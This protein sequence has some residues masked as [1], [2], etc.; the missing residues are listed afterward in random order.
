MQKY[1]TALTAIQQYCKRIQAPYREG[2][3]VIFFVRTPNLGVLCLPGCR[4]RTSARRSPPRDHLAR[5]RG[6][7]LPPKAEAGVASGTTG[8]AARVSMK[9]REGRPR[10][11][12]KFRSL[13][14]I[15]HVVQ[16][17]D[18]DKSPRTTFQETAVNSSCNSN[19]C[20]LGC[21]RGFQRFRQK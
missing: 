17:Y 10:R 13:L 19:H 9:R 18:T 20:V 12:G 11:P 14:R 16:Q 8:A 2:S 6:R 7:V 3:R 4:T 1:T 15:V 5:N 21:V